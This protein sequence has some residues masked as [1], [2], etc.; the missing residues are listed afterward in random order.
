[1]L[2]TWTS[3]FRR[4]F[5]RSFF[6][7][8]I[9]HH[10][11]HSHF[12]STPHLRSFVSIL[13][14]SVALL[15]DSIS[16]CC[17]WLIYIVSQ[18]FKNVQVRLPLSYI[19]YHSAYFMIPSMLLLYIPPIVAFCTTTQY[20]ASMFQGRCI[21]CSPNATSTIEMPHISQNSTNYSK[22]PQKY[23]INLQ[24]LPKRNKC[25]QSSRILPKIPVG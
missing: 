2:S 1:M 11:F 4:V 16:H 12:F 10:P 7:W 20:L 24:I 15:F 8:F 22:V 6:F 14:L 21:C 5:I 18:I 19:V 3:F 13:L 9:H 25:I 23:P 17:F